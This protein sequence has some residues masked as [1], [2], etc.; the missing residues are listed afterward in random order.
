MLLLIIINAFITIPIDFRQIVHI[1]SRSQP[2][3]VTTKGRYAEIWST[4]LRGSTKSF[5]LHIELAGTFYW[6]F[7]GEIPSDE[8]PFYIK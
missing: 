6:K 4:I 7:D 3:F 2:E 5:K 1:V 8:S